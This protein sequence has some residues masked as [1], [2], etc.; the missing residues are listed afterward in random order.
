VNKNDAPSKGKN[1][2]GLA[3]Q[4]LGVQTIAVTKRPNDTT[5][6]EFGLRVLAPDAAHAL[7]ALR[8]GERVGHYFQC[9]ERQKWRM[10]D[11]FHR[12]IWIPLR[13]KFNYHKEKMGM[14]MTS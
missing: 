2:V 8:R 12:L 13:F 4:V 1:N 3:R 5:Y 11:S 6:D 14:F 9:S 7:A 10:E